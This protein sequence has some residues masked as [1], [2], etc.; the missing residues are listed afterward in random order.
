MCRVFAQVL[1]LVHVYG[2]EDTEEVVMSSIDDDDQFDWLW[3][4]M[5]DIPVHVNLACIQVCNTGMG[6]LYYDYL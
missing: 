6:R 1:E 4:P 2:V 3:Q 5:C